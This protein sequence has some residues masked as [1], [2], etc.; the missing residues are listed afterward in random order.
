MN[1]R[2]RFLAV[3]RFEEPDYTPVLSCNGINGPSMYTLGTWHREQ[4]FPGWVDSPEGWDEFW[5]MTRVRG[6]S[7]GG[8]GE[9]MPQP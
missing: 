3:S 7:P 5:G 2:Q 1:A 6:W 9:D 8:P 4:D